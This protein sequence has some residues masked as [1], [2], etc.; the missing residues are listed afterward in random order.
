MINSL[1]GFASWVCLILK[2]YQ[3]FFGGPPKRQSMVIDLLNEGSRDT[4]ALQQNGTEITAKDKYD[5]YNFVHVGNSPFFK[6][7]STSSLSAQVIANMKHSNFF[8]EFLQ[9]KKLT[10]RK[11]SSEIYRTPTPELWPKTTGSDYF[12]FCSCPRVLTTKRNDVA[13]HNFHT[14]VEFTCTRDSTLST[15]IETICESRSLSDCEVAICLI[16]KA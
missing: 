10:Q 6:F 11:S 15:A 14:E 13:T 7:V 12:L 9:H 1:Y 8:G 16:A 2:K 5:R 3:S 4:L